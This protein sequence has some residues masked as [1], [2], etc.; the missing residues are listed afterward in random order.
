MSLAS[1]S[2]AELQAELARRQSQAGKLIAKRDKLLAQIAELDKELAAFGVAGSGA[3]APAKGRRGRPPGS[4]SKSGDGRRG[5]RPKNDISLPDAIAQAME[6]R[7]VASP[8][9]AAELVL[10]NG[11]KSNAKNFGM[12]VSNALA[13]DPRFKRLGRGQY[14]RIK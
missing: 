11:Y 2:T 12:L 8:K 13:K 6:I 3:A 7:A 5:P 10:S 9:E 14:E 1:M 4:S